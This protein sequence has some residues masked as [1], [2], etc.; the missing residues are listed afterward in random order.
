[1]RAARFAVGLDV[2]NDALDYA[3]THYSARFVQGSAT[4]LP[5]ASASFELVTAFEV[6][7]HLEDWPNLI[8]EARRV[9]QPHGIFLVST[10]N[11]LYY[12][13]SRGA[14]GKN[15][16]HVHEFTYAE[17]RDALGEH[18][19][20]VNILQQNRTESFAFTSAEPAHIEMRAD[21]TRTDPDQAH[22]FLAVCGIERQPEPRDFLYLPKASNLLREREQHIHKLE[23]ELQL[24]KEFLAKALDDHQTLMR[25]HAEQK[26]H[27]EERNRWALELEANWRAAQARIVQLQEEF[28]AEQ[29][30]A[31]ETAAG[32]AAKVTQ[33]EEEN[34]EKTQWALDTEARLAAELSAK[35]E[36]LLQT[37]SLLQQAEATVTERT[38]WAQGLQKRVEI[39]EAQLQMIRASRWVRMGRIV[40]VGPKV[41]S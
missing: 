20:H 19:P 33:L 25:L 30:A 2:S 7:E 16:F 17:F 23:D 36:E 5:F 39:L 14:E 38:V 18:F 3:R 24:T 11:R 35:C 1:M 4:A 22:F 37:V 9:L 21:N 28:R 10:P 12:T 40:G 29:A 15:P 41:Q 26:E 27:L 6:I 31:Q 8:A 32:Y 34:R 13:E